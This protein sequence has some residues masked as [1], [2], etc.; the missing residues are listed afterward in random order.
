MTKLQIHHAFSGKHLIRNNHNI[1]SD[2]DGFLKVDL[3][4][5]TCECQWG[6]PIRVDD[7]GKEKP[8]IYCVHKLRAMA[9]I[10]E[11]DRESLLWPY[12][13][14]LSTRYNSFETVSAFHKELRRGNLDK[15]FLWASVLSTYR[16]LK[17]VLKYMLNIVYEETR[18][19]GLAERLLAQY[20]AAIDQT[21]DVADVCKTIAYFCQAP[22]KWELSHR[23]EVFSSEMDGYKLL[24]DKYGYEVARA[25]EIIAKSEFDHLRSSLL[26]GFAD[27]DRS[28]VQY[29]LKGLFKSKSDLAH[30]DHKLVIF[31]LLSDILDNEFVNKFNYDESGAMR[32]QHFIADRYACIGDI[33]Y[34]EINALCDALSGESY[35]AGMLPP[36]RVK[37]IQRL[38]KLPSV[39]LGVIPSIPLYAHDNHTWAGKALMRSYANQLR[40]G[41]KQTNLD[42]RWCGAYFGVAWRHLAYNQHGTCDVPWESVK[43]PQSLYKHVSAMWY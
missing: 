37:A 32:I 21:P 17:G 27:A 22:K 25:K 31:K 28:L 9:A 10:V 23:F 41:A 29:G 16:G 6:K 26:R 42:F 14:A 11:N 38:K 4:N 39:P 20:Q 3:T 40:P 19:H 24:A 15:A 8:N 2:K 30:E 7:S 1:G 12:L 35:E 36:L 18:D 33:G 43:W 5:N 13:K 34:H